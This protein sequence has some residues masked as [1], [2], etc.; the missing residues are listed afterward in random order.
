MTKTPEVYRIPEGEKKYRKF[1]DDLY[2]PITPEFIAAL[3][4]IKKEY[5]SW[6]A[7][8][9]T[10]GMKTRVMRRYRQP[11]KSVNPKRNRNAVSLHTV[12]LILTRTH[13]PWW[14]DRFPWYT[15]DELIEHGIWREPKLARQ[16]N[17]PLNPNFTPHLYAPAR[18]AR[19]LHKTSIP[20][21]LEA[22]NPSAV[23]RGEENVV[24]P[25]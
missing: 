12:D 18:L 5:G 7:V 4:T 23:H 8:C 13:R 14:L 24:S 9:R 16:W 19:K 21:G 3:T 6:R 17:D 22:F 25:D 20:Y 10:V 11:S 1:R 15:I 2:T